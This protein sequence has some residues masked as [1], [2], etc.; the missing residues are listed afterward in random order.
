[1][2]N[3]FYFYIFFAICVNNLA[4]CQQVLP[5]YT[6][7]IP[8]S[9]IAKNEEIVKN[10]GGIII[11]SKI[12]K[13]T[14]TVFLPSKK[15]A[16]GTA[17]IICPGGGYWV[18]AAKHEGSDV[19]KKFTEMGITVFV[20]KYRIPNSLWMLNPEIGP[21]QDAQ[22]AIKIVRDNAIKWNLNPNKIGI[23]GFSAGGHLAST[24]GTH[25][26]KTYITNSS[27]TNLR[28]SF[29]LLIYPVISF[30]PEIGH[31]GSAEQLIG[32]TPTQQKII[33]YSNET[34]VSSL[35]PPTFLV[36]A[37]D[38]DAVRPLNSIAF[39]TA[40]INNK[41]PSELH[42]Y[43]SGGHGFGLYFKNSKEFWMDRCKNWLK[44]NGWLTK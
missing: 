11:I 10:E 6:D 38:D 42:I 25:F 26:N 32:K 35:T 20:L 43:Q 4:Y 39:Y 34:Q 12:S 19:A 36:H 28:P 15:T 29:M 1:M 22:Q 27:N 40:L 8:N 31:L 21:I 2:M 9:K 16:N 41:V 44:L 5:L 33:E 13:P 37:S 7:S 23:M 3:Q 24:A 17:V 18:V 14:L 30:T